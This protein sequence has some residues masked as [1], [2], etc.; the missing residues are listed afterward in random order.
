[1][2]SA[3]EPDRKDAFATARP[4]PRWYFGT[5]ELCRDGSGSTVVH[6]V[7]VHSS[8]LNPLQD[9]VVRYCAGEDS[10]ASALNKA[11]AE[12]KQR[13]YRFT[14]LEAMRASRVGEWS[15]TELV[16]KDD[17]ENQSDGQ[18]QVVVCPPEASGAVFFH[19]V[20]G[21]DEMHFRDLRLGVE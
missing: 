14:I 21:G 20:I 11:L 19:F 12:E 6:T 17:D 15:S 16:V 10:V 3:L 4:P 1:M 9:L 18:G 8:A 7:L 5:V 13:T 2:S